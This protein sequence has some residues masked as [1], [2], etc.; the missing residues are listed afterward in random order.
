V[1]TSLSDTLSPCKH[2]VSILIIVYTELVPKLWSETIEGHRRAVHDATLETTAA[3]VAEHGLRSVTMSKIAE[4]T[5]IGRATLYKYFSDVDAI[6]IA[7]HERHVTE[8]LRQL[9]EIRERTADVAK[10]VEVVLETYALI[11]HQREQHGS[12]LTALL[13]RGEHV[14]RAQQQLRDFIR[15]VLAEGAASGD[16]RDDV[17]P[18]ELASYALHALS[19]AGSL[20]TKAAVRRLVAV[21]LAG[22]R[23]PR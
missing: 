18:D 3:L 22:L 12:E 14:A 9:A 7:W 8:H 4:E 20:S 19:A 5:G 10:R 15:D 17:A 21:T 23:T 13:H 1:G 6:L 16:I 2:G 11:S